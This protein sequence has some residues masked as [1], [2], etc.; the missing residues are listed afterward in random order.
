MPC[1]SIQAHSIWMEVSS[2]VGGILVSLRNNSVFNFCPKFR[3]CKDSE[4]N[5][6]Q[7]TKLLLLSFFFA[8]SLGRTLKFKK[9]WKHVKIL[10]VLTKD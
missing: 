6:I 7:P 5:I 4:G 1:I 10:S 8:A 3:L 2:K 9:F